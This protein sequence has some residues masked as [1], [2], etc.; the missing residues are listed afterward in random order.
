MIIDFHT[1]V[2]PPEVVENRERFVNRDP[3]FSLV[4]AS[5]RARMVTLEGHLEVM[6]GEGVDAAVVCGFPWADPGISE[7]ANAYL[8]DAQA[9]FPERVHAFYTPPLSGRDAVLRGAQDALDKGMKGIG[10]AAFYREEMKTED[11]ACLRELARIAGHFDRPLLLH[12]NEPVGHDYP[13]KVEMRVRDI[14][15]FASEVPDLTLVLAHWGGGLFFYELMKSVRRSV[16]RLYYDTAASPYLYEPSIYR[17]ATEILGPDR[18]LFGSDFPL[19]RPSRYFQE[20]DAAGLTPET[21][22]R[23]L[24]ENARRVLGI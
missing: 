2:F 17:I 18:V 24:G 7:M 10:E 21:K 9:R 11:W 20:I 4:Y 13:G 19:I 1:H 22:N 23:L 5:P 3:V 12:V 15:R 14:W 6:A 8:L 16:G